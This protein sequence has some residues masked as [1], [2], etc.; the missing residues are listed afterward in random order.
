MV[1]CIISEEL[2]EEQ[3]ELLFDYY[4]LDIDDYSD[5]EI[6]GSRPDVALKVSKKKLIKSI[7]KGRLEISSDSDNG[8]SVVQKLVGKYKDRT[9]LK[10]KPLTGRAKT[11]QSK[12]KGDDH[13][14]RMYAMLGV[15]CGQGAS[16]ILSLEGPD[17]STAE[18]LGGLFLLA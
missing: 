2:A 16:A 11:E 1:E 9:E 8:L 15:M 4:D 17:L 6:D 5:I 13:H 14:G 7:R 10:Y 12:F 18:C 3:L